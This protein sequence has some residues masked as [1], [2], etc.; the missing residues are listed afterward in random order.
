MNWSNMKKTLIAV[1]LTVNFLSRSNKNNSNS[2]VIEL[3]VSS[4][5]DAVHLKFICGNNSVI[6]RADLII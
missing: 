5:D 3:T 6:Q 1:F 4:T 2:S